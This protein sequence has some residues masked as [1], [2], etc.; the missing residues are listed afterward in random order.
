MPTALPPPGDAR[1]VY[2][3]DLSGFVFRAYH[4]L[5]PLSNSKGEPTHATLGM[6]NMLNRLVKD[7]RPVY[8]A[9]AMDSKSEHS[10]RKKL[11]PEYKATRPA[12]PP[13]LAQQMARCREL[14]EAYEIPVLAQ[15]GY[16]ADDLLAAAVR[17]ARAH[18][19]RTV[20]CSADKDLMQLVADDVVMWDAMRNR[21]FGVDEVKEKW[22]VAPDKVCDLLALMGDT[23]DNVPGVQ[24]IGEKTA[25]K[26]I[27]EHGSLDGV[28]AHLDQLKG[29]L[30]ENLVRDEANARVSYKL[31]CLDHDLPTSLDLETLRYGGWDARKLRSLLLQLEFNRLADAV[32]VDASVVVAAETPSTPQPQPAMPAA[33]KGQQQLSFGDATS[34]SA[35][36]AVASI[37]APLTVQPAEYETVLDAAA[38]AHVVRACRDAGRFA[39][40]LMTN[41]AE[42]MR[43]S[44]VGVALA[45]APRKAAYVP[46]GHRVIG[47]PKQLARGEIFEALTPL[48]RDPAIAKIAHD[49]KYDE[50]V[51]RRAG[52]EVEGWSFDTML[53]SYLNDPERHTH[54]LDEIALAELN[55]TMQSLDAV[56]KRERGKTLTI[57]EVDIATAAKVAAERADIVMMASR[58]LA[59]RLDEA[60]LASLLRDLE[61]PL[62]HVLARVEEI[63]VRVDVPML[64]TLS[65]Q[66]GAEIDRLEKKLHEL[67]GREFNV[68]SPRQLETILFDELKLPVLKRTKTSRS[69]DHEVLEE[70]G[71]EHEIAR[72]ILEHRQLTKLRGT[73]LDA[74][75]ALVN[76]STGRIHTTYS[77]AVAATGRLSSNNPNL[78]NI[79]IRSEQGGRIREAFVADPGFEIL[80]AD[81]S[82]IELRVL[83]H[84][85]HDPIL[86]D[87]F[88]KNEDIHTRTAMEI[89]KVSADAV[90]REM[91]AQAKTTNFAVLYGQGQAALSRNLG[92][93]RR[94]ASAFIEKY[95]QTFPGLTK[96]LDETVRRARAGEAV[97]T[98]LGRRRFLPT[99][100]SENRGLRAQAERIAKN[101]PIQGTAADIM[102]LAMIH[103]DQRLRAENLATR[104]ILTVHDELVFEVPHAEASRVGPIVRDTMESAI[105]LDVPLVV[106][107]GRGSNW[108]AAH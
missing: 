100:S 29:K 7:Q 55:H 107:M 57:D 12:P 101:T 59:A 90:T 70:L 72:R 30:K 49:V 64:K 3:L 99:I 17:E 43:A 87:A 39:V 46:V 38:L 75:P 15:D 23:S 11:Y 67:A 10:I 85:S 56:L 45:W 98:L 50:M 71:E 21:V 35:P 92:I 108:G 74:L 96:F 48:L 91:R 47:D 93:P 65:A 89:F 13:D 102:K 9:V 53:A 104:M 8:L 42:A 84:L 63:G 27:T 28:Y 106:G 18:G 69:T 32:P 80:S 61:M 86:V 95:F 79:P 41:H 34:K 81:Y 37:A 4:A 22:G 51:W 76:P 83:A 78:Q 44:V 40:G 82:Q 33:V 6:A 88:Q 105:K 24:G 2:V 5:P 20:I 52:V 97:R 66:F 36:P 94:E 19:L 103:I 73:Y 60:Q 68:N 14:V 16:E 54:R 26:L 25:A 58:T 62:T 77:Q 31:V 1:T